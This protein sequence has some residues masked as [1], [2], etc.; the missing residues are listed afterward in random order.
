MPHMCRC[1]RLE[2]R[3]PLLKIN[4]VT[5]EIGGAFLQCWIRDVVD[6]RLVLVGTRS[7]C[8]RLRKHYLKSVTWR[9]NGISFDLRILKFEIFFL[10]LSGCAVRSSEH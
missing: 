10:L 1:E 9:I 7:T 6:S 5:N 4:H 2:R 3:E 8:R